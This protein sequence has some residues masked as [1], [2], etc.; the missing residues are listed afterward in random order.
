[1]LSR[2][3]LFEAPEVSLARVRCDGADAC[4]HVISDQC[5][6]V[7]HGSFAVRHRRGRAVVDPG[8][9]LLWRAGN[10]I[11]IRHPRCEGDECL[12]IG[13]PLVNRLDFDTIATRP[14]GE[15]AWNRLRAADDPLALAVALAEAFDAP[16][17]SRHR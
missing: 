11:D 7:M 6:I 5:V 16:T 1:M 14:V 9:A 2:R 3:V 10:D 17:P 13:G 15:R 8:Q 4:E 12:A